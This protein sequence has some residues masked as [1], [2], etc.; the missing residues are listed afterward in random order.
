MNAKRL[1]VRTSND[2]IPALLLYQ[3][4]GFRITEIRIGVMVEH[5]GAEIP[6]WE[7]IPVRD[8]VIL[9]K[10]LLHK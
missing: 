10:S 7:G 3:K 5:H 2:N 4:N 8:E 9:E 1:V 6:G